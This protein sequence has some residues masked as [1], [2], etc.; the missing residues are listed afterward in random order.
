MLKNQIVG[1]SLLISLFSCA[2]PEQLD[3]FCTK[4][5]A[6]TEGLNDAQSGEAMNYM[7]Y[8]QCRAERREIAISGYKEGYLKGKELNQPKA[9][10]VVSQ[11]AP[12]TQNSGISIGIGRNGIQ[13]NTG[14]NTPAQNPA[15]G[16]QSAVNP[17]AWYC[18]AEAFT[19]K[20][21]AFGPT[22]LEAKK[23]V[24]DQCIRD[25]HEMHCKASCKPNQ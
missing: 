6:F 13:I 17:K 3:A 23:T 16:A 20:Y 18:Q 25:H 2:T 10:V 1:A 15:P 9:P 19:K 8:S 21:D 7:Q 4:D 5:A 24:M 12:Q 14:G 22:Q 11:P